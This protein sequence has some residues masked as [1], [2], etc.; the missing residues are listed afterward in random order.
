MK[1][2]GIERRK[3]KS[4]TYVNVNGDI[5]L[6]DNKKKDEMKKNDFSDPQVNLSVNWFCI[7]CKFRFI[8][9]YRNSLER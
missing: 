9:I 2:D 6:Q 5:A 4:Q 7:I 8:F 1:D 3:R